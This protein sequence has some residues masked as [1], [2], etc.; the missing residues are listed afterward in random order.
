M[1]KNL[2]NSIKKLIIKSKEPQ[3]DVQV[4][5]QLKNGYLQLKVYTS[6]LLNLSL[7]TIN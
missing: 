6:E 2:C 3:V 5:L 7:E 1:N 4:R